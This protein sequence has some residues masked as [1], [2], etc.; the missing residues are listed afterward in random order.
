MKDIFYSL[1]KANHLYETFRIEFDVDE[2]VFND[3]TYTITHLV[4]NVYDD[5]SE[6][7]YHYF[8]KND[9]FEEELK[10]MLLT[11]G[12]TVIFDGNDEN[13]YKFVVELKK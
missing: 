12:F 2:W 7:K 6:G 11:N 9:C 5:Y 10:T 3:S 1:L 8:G 13:D 4:E